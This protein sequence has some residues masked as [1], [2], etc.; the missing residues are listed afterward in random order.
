MRVL[1][2]RYD[3]IAHL[4]SNAA[5][6]LIT[7][8]FASIITHNLPFRAIIVDLSKAQVTPT[9]KCILKL[10]SFW[11]VFVCFHIRFW[12]VFRQFHPFNLQSGVKSGVS[13]I[14]R[15]AENRRFVPTTI[16]PQTIVNFNAFRK[17]I[18]YRAFLLC[19]L[20]CVQTFFSGCSNVVSLSF[21]KR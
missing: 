15:T 11:C 4:T 16:I 20:F 7:A 19:T 3:M 18:A 9:R 6:P 2:T 1:R 17:N 14:G 12:A 8:S 13:H 21:E 10:W 5:K